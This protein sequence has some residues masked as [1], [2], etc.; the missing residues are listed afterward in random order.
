MQV[1]QV[2]R[3]CLV[4]LSALYNL[5]NDWLHKHTSISL[6]KELPLSLLLQDFFDGLVGMDS[7]ELLVILEHLLGYLACHFILHIPALGGGNRGAVPLLLLVLLLGLLGGN[8]A[9]ERGLGLLGLS[10]SFTVRV[11]TDGIFVL[12]FSFWSLLLFKGSGLV[13]FF[14]DLL[15]PVL[16]RLDLFDSVLDDGE[17]LSNL[18]V[19]H[20]LIIVQVISE[21]EQLVY[22]CLLVILLFLFGGGP[23][24]LLTFL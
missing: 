19:L 22:F 8:L 7:S 11:H 2:T 10:A 5:R 20:E 14:S 4:H 17:G 24:W 3:V 18:E 12:G 16:V 1:W 23:S 15:L 21:L 9:L 13:P 6:E